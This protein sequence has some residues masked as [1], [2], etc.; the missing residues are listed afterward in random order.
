MD[1]T[2]YD[3]GNIFQTMLITNFINS[4]ELDIESYFSSN[5]DYLSKLT[6]FNYVDYGCA[7]GKNTIDLFN[8]FYS[9]FKKFNSDGSFTITF[10]D[11]PSNDFK[12]TYN[13]FMNSIMNQS[14]NS[15]IYH[16]MV[17]G[18]FY[19]N[20]L[21]AKSADLITCNASIH[22]LRMD[23]EEFYKE[24]EN[25][26]LYESGDVNLKIIQVSK[27]NYFEFLI[28]RYKELKDEG[29]LVISAPLDIQNK[30]GLRAEI[31]WNVWD[32]T[33]KKLKLEKL[34]KYM[35]IK[36]YIR[37]KDEYLN[38]LLCKVNDYNYEILKNEI[39][40]T[41]VPIYSPESFVNFLK[42]FLSYNFQRIKNEFYKKEYEKDLDEKL[43][44]SLKT[45]YFIE[46]KN[47]YTNNKKRVIEDFTYSIIYLILRK[48]SF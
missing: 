19:D 23:D 30:K 6:N 48:K 26:P 39:R 38:P 44:E 15:S 18:N 10:S 22:W 36:T 43:Y 13:C 25:T 28:N 4:Y 1:S 7:T 31:I 8:L 21:P 29:L 45:E 32:E 27:E 11:L 42:P 12:I 47:F 5:K 9:L 33:L 14:L 46:L 16:R 17:I 37:S 2:L 35:T 41:K 24:S 20:L 40:E 34:R 3:E